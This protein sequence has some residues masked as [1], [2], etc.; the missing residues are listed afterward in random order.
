MRVRW[1]A[2]AITE[3]EST[4]DFWSQKNKSDAYS[5]KIAI[6]A[7][8][9]QR[10]LEENPYFLARYIEEEDIYQR[11]FFKGKF[12]LYYQIKEEVVMILR[13]RSTKQEPLY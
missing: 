12:V 3:L 1:S 6:E 4:L 13:F 9:V 11:V 5:E 10:E 2:K 8:N 7:E